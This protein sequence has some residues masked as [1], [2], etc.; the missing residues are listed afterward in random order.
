MPRRATYRLQ[1][2][3]EF[4]LS[5]AA[6]QA[7]YLADLGVSHVYCSPYLQAAAGST[8]GYDVVDPT[9]VSDDLGG[10]DAH[11]A[12][13]AAL[14]EAG[15]VQLLDIVPNH[16][17]IADRRN[18]WWWD[19]LADGQRSP[20][21]D[22]FD[23][24]WEVDEPRL[25]HRVL[26]PILGDQVGRVIERG[27]IR[28]VREAGALLIGY[29][30]HR[31]PLR[32]ETI[33]SLLDGID[34]A[35]PIVQRI[36]ALPGDG[37]ESSRLRR[38][39]ERAAISAELAALLEDPGVAPQVD[40]RLAAINADI[41]ALDSILNEQ[42]HRLARWQTAVE[43]VNY[44]RFFDIT[45]LVA[46]RIEDPRV[47][48]AATGFVA[49]LVES[50]E[51]DGLRVDHIDGLR[52]PLEYAQRLRD[53]TGAAWLLAEKI[54]ARHEQPPAWALDGTSGYDFLA[55]VNGVLVDP[56]GREALVALH[57]E[58]TGLPGD[59]E[60][61]ALDG[62]RE[63]LR[64]TLVAD[65]ERL[66][67]LLA[68]VSDAYPAHRDHTR[69]EL[70][71]ALV[72]MIAALPVYRT[73]VDPAR[74]AASD[75]DA[76]L[77]RGAAAAARVNDPDLDQRLLDFIAD[78]F[79][80]GQAEDVATG[81]HRSVRAAQ[82]DL[83]L[84]FQQV[85]AATAA[86]GVEDTA[87]YR[88]LA[89]TS[90]NEVGDSPAFFGVTVD[91]FHEH[92]ARTQASRPLAM[93]ATS[94][95]DTKRSEDVR[96]RI[97]LI[98]E[99]PD[100]WATAVRR[101]QAMNS[102]HRHGDAPGPAMEY[103][104][105]QTLVGAL[106]ITSDRAVAYMEKAAHEAKLQTSWL[107]PDEAYDAALRDFTS[108]VLGDARF[109]ADITAFVTTLV[110][111]ARTNSLAMTL[112]KLTSPGVPDIYQG[113][114]LWDHSLVDPDN[115]RP[116]D[117][118]VRRTLLDAAAGR[119]PADAWREQPDSGAAKQWLIAAALQLRQRAPG[120]FDER[121]DYAP[122]HAEGSFADDVIAFGRGT[123]A[124][125]TVIAQR[126]PLRRRGEWSDTMISL[127]AGEWR[128]LCDG[129]SALHGQL[130]LAALLERFP[131]ALLERT[132]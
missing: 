45:S 52:L 99:I 36:R 21:A 8:H 65:V 115:R 4:D 89:L 70:S 71:A 120:A 110:P 78:L 20:Y 101:W 13:C 25:H 112:L 1:L 63:I 30:D 74:G 109:L 117:Y 46:L 66:T 19:V 77:I 37:D 57:E 76:G 16:M 31:F 14:R 53:R 23:I 34:R 121:G 49:S 17:S 124:A 75:T 5:A 50:G 132:A 48:E 104:L 93:L 59:F 68:T 81:E 95:H 111:F 118:A 96:C 42:H 113:C 94:T 130:D 44:R 82:E 55:L 83:V 92:N 43:E 33:A 3:A 39:E 105:Y 15:L 86:K 87:C 41:A 2:R 122:M 91:E 79:V 125:V 28:L 98:S 72:E 40:A 128:N 56:S 67:T 11:R 84:R 129:A 69:S 58:M 102:V 64:T 24:D 12:F 35:R 80:F 6:A 106:P 22:F 26:V 107:H 126:R 9:R 51:V 61:I 7:A 97:D 54:L 100:E 108:A 29:F 60:L 114:E 88:H 85:C 10:P 119:T 127:P 38:F 103:L 32:V 62:K 123:P 131:V 18:R 27:E 90:L 116:V 47:F 73:Y